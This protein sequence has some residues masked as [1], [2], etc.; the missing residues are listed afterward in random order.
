MKISVFEDVW[1]PR[2]VNYKVGDN[3]CNF[4]TTM[5]SDL[6]DNNSR[7]W[8]VDVVK[9]TH[10]HNDAAR[11]FRVP[12]AKEAH[13]DLLV[14]RGEPTWEF[15]VRSVYKMLLKGTTDSTV[16]YI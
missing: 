8:K 6:I 3:V 9:N 2:A 15:L 11:I 12:L 4:A 7:E 1:L 10:T 16:N 14:W 13:D 5:V